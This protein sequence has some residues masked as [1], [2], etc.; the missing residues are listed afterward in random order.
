MTCD[1][2]IHHNCH[3]GAGVR[4]LEGEGRHMDHCR[5][6]DPAAAARDRPECSSFT[7][8]DIVFVMESAATSRSFRRFLGTPGGGGGERRRGHDTQQKT[9][10]MTDSAAPDSHPERTPPARLRPPP[11][12]SPGACEWGWSQPTWSVWASAW[13]IR[14]RGWARSEGSL[15]TGTATQS[16]SQERN[17]TTEKHST[18]AP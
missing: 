6:W 13:S 7:S 9:K 15:R 11:P 2:E 16:A 10:W 18:S 14:R 1:W 4:P 17:T 8:D 3:T 12:G 5:L